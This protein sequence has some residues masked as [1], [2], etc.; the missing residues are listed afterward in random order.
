MKTQRALDAVRPAFVLQSCGPG[1]MYQDD[2]E[3]L[4]SGGKVHRLV[5][6][7]RGMVWLEIDHRGRIHVRTFRQ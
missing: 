6:A 5:T 4:L 7:E 2:W 1:R 3:P